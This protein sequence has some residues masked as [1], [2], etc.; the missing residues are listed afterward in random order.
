MASSA[1]LQSLLVLV[2]FKSLRSY[3]YHSQ[4]LS[5]RFNFKAFGF[6]LLNIYSV[7]PFQAI[8]RF[9]I[10]AN[11]FSHT[12]VWTM[13]ITYSLIFFSLLRGTE[14]IQALKKMTLPDGRK[15]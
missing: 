2:L 12:L 11:V 9:S 4:G 7:F 8:F 3:G 6:Y 10:V 1:P 5:L 14:E 15:T 13:V